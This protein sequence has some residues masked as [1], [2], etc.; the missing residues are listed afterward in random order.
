MSAG[1]TAAAAAVAA[2]AAAAGRPLD[3]SSHNPHPA[4]THTHTYTR[5]L[6]C[7]K[8]KRLVAIRSGLLV[9]RGGYWG[10]LRAA[11]NPLFHTAA[12][13]TYSPI[14]NDSGKWVG[15][16]WVGRVVYR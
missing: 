4:H 11:M 2:A 12:L 9:S 7:S 5:R 3:S 8:N 13:H 6:P 14:I 15:V 16:G 1:L 10:S